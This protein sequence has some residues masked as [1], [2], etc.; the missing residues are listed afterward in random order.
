MRPYF[1]SIVTEAGCSLDPLWM[2]IFQ[3]E[4]LPDLL[5]FPTSSKSGVAVTV[6]QA[7]ASLLPGF[8]PPPW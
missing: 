7:Y 6:Y 2:C 8:S 1:V 4:K 3:M 5:N